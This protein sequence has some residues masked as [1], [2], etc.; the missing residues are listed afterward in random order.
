MNKRKVQVE[1]L[2]RKLKGFT[3]LQKVAIP[4]TGWLKA[5]RFSLRTSLLQ[6]ANKLSITKQSV[7]E[8]EIREKAGSITLKNLRETADAL[9][10]QLVCGLVPNDGS[11]DALID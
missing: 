8:I 4:P 7:L 1:Q 2:D 6:L 9:D 10:R 3:V 5:V 11:L